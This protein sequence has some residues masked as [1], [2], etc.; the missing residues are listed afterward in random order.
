MDVNRPLSAY[1][2]P[3]WVGERGKG[4]CMCG[5]RGKGAC[6]CGERGKGAC[7]CGPE[8]KMNEKKCGIVG[9]GGRVCAKRALCSSAGAS[10]VLI[11]VYICLHFC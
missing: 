11:F 9:P 4:A 5:E 7:M 2:G 1:I 6:M 10:G 3:L 8:P